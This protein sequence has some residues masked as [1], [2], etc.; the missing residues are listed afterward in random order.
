M[1]QTSLDS[2]FYMLWDGTLGERQAMVLTFISNFPKCTDQ[3]IAK[4]LGFKDPNAVRPRRKELLDQGYIIEC[5]T[6][7]CNITGRRS[8]IWKVK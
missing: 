1:R 2:Y 3:E 8:T 7:I 5:G 4:G 6:K